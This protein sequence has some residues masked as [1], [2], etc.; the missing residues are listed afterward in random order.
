MDATNLFINA[1]DHWRDSKGI[2]TAL[3]PPPLNDKVMILGVL[4]RIYSKNPNIISLI[5]V[6]NFTE[7]SEIIEF[8][9]Q[10]DDENNNAEFKQLIGDKKIK[11]FTSKFIEDGKF[12]MRVNVAIVYHCEEIGDRLHKLLSTSKFRLVVLN[13]LKLNT[14]DLN[15]LYALCPLL[16]DFRQN[17]LDA[18]R[19]STP[20]EEM[21]IGITIP[22]NTKDYQLLKYYD[23]YIATSINIFGSFDNIQYARVG[24]PK[25]NISAT[26]FC[27]KIASDN[28]WSDDLDMSI[29]YNVQIDALYNPANIR[30]R[31]T[32]TY[33]VI[34]N[35]AKLLSDY[36]AKLDEILNIVKEHE[37]DRILVINKSGEF[38]AKVTDFLN[39]M[40]EKEVCGNYHD[41]VE[42]IPAC[43]IDGNPIYVKSG[44]DK[45]ER[46]MF[47]AKAQ[48]TY[49]E[50]R[51][52]LNKIHVL[53]T[54][55][56]PDKNL[57]IPVD[58]III[59]STQCEDI[60]SY[61][62]RLS[63]VVYPNKV[64]KLYT[65]Y[66]K[67]S[68]EEKRLQSKNLSETHILLNDEKNIKIEEKF[69]FVVV[70]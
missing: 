3:I 58:V 59:T 70:D 17:E 16:S 64:I 42:L 53:S 18:L 54:N 35:R 52:R 66:I 4:Q 22:E 7:R 47:A 32:Q 61:I 57:N 19:T 41:H 33:E 48:K 31:A 28:G 11:L 50:E 36:D 12:D 29:E 20:V 21:R 2:G 39:N 23:E 40:L 9:T 68:I 49:N 24:Y 38:A 60:E 56:T 65:L 30:D 55:N 46:K 67:D 34:R 45:G 6:N 26:Q 63:K 25:C 37:F 13:R 8:L 43:D 5:V 14:E 1:I 10:Q 15:K 62:Y 51:F 69:D 27:H 44:K